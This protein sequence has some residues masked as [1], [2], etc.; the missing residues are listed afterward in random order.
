VRG[1]GIRLTRRAHL[2][3]LWRVGLPTGLQFSLEVGAFALLTG[4]LA[5]LSETEAAAHQIAIQV[6]HFSFL[7]AFAVAEAGSVLA[8]QAVGANRDWLVLTVARLGLVAS[9]IYTGACT[10]ILAFF[11]PLLV[12]GFSAEGPLAAEAVRLLYVAAV[13][14]IFD[15]ANIVARAT[16]R[17]TGDV[18]FA[19]VVGI[20]TSWMFTPPL[21]WLLGW[22]AGMG[23]FGGW[24]GLSAEIIVASVIL[25]VRLERKGWMPA[26]AESRRRL[27]EVKAKAN[28]EGAAT[29]WVAA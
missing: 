4:M 17:G 5:A 16:L 19:A 14:Q 9:T 10:V 20:V 23:A 15:G 28:K 13:F 22:K 1:W 12:S 8:G 3:E 21:T 11:A 2:V 6:I 25:W 18:R 29:D 7:P 24:L 26:A 27:A